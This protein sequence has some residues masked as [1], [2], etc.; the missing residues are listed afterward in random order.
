LYLQFTFNVLY[1]TGSARLTV[2]EFTNIS[3][4]I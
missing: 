2:D 4:K 1:Y 3:K